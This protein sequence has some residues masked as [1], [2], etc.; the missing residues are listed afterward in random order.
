MTE[1]SRIQDLLRRVFEGEAFHGPSINQILQDV[2]AEQAKR[3]PIPQ[4][5]TIWEITE[6]IAGWQHEV[7]NRL[8][9]QVAKILPPEEN[10]PALKDANQAAWKQTLRKLQESYRELSTAISQFP[11]SR[12]EETVP[13]RKY[14]F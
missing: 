10:F 5:H 6:H 11:E 13:G 2:S 12:F 8:K 1:I 4:G 14:T 3:R 9:G 7:S